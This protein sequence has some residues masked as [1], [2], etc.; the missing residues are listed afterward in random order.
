MPIFLQLSKNIC[1]FVTYRHV[2]A[3][4]NLW[5]L[6]RK[7]MTSAGSFTSTMYFNYRSPKHLIFNQ[8][9]STVVSLVWMNTPT[10]CWMKR[11]V[12]TVQRVTRKL[13]TPVWCNAKQKLCTYYLKLKSTSTMIIIGMVDYCTFPVKGLAVNVLLFSLWVASC[14]LSGQCEWSLSKLRLYYRK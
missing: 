11:N 9:S 6:G 13:E 3:K 2:A 7:E 12:H 5:I 1:L 4:W 10:E 14:Y 8:A